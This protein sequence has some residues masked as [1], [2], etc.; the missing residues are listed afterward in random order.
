M[1]SMTGGFHA[2]A[3]VSRIARRLQPAEIDGL[4]LDARGF[5]AVA[6]VTGV[7]LFNG[8][9]FFQYFEGLNDSVE[10]VYERIKPAKCHTDIRELMNAPVEGRQFE[11]WHMGFRNAPATALQ[12]LA[13]ARWELSV[14]VTRTSMKC[15]E[16]VALLAHF[17]SKWQAENPRDWQAYDRSDLEGGE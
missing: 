6:G 7:L 8:S 2:I 16:G 4:L 11:T 5:N 1:T 14:P 15:P 12:E 17:W 13:Q 10:A 3:Y 9:E